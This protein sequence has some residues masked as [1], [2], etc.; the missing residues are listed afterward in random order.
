MSPL[1]PHLRSGKLRALGATS[2]KRV[3]A[4]VIRHEN[5]P[6]AVYLEPARFAV[7]IAPARALPTTPQRC[8]D[9]LPMGR[10]SVFLFFAFQS[11]GGWP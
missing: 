2:P 6:I 3:P 9:A 1:L 7:V 10:V 8:I 5:A 11:R 4:L